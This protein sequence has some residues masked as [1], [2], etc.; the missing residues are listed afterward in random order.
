MLLKEIVLGNLKSIKNRNINVLAK[1]PFRSIEK[2]T[3]PTDFSTVS[4]Q[5]AEPDAFF[6][7][8]SQL[9]PI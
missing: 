6:S 3:A 5:F 7:P 2:Y 1:C 4:P 8:D 9:L